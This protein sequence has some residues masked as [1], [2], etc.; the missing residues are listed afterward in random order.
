MRNPLTSV[1]GARLRGFSVKRYLTIAFLVLTLLSCS[2]LLSFHRE[3][4]KKIKYSK[5]EFV[6]CNSPDNAQYLCLTEKDAIKSVMDLKKCQEQ[7]N[8]MRE[9]LNGN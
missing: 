2:G 1:L 5:I 8:L 3:L 7:N 6:D 4:P 9:L